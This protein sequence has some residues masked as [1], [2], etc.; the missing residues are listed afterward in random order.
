[1]FIARARTY[2]LAPFRGAEREFVFKGDANSAPPYGA[3]G[4]VARCYKHCTLK[5]GGTGCAVATLLL[6]RAATQIKCA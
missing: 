3:G 4:R 2:L 5:R 6:Y 1:M